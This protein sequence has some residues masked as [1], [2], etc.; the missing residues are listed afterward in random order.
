MPRTGGEAIDPVGELFGACLA[1]K[2]PGPGVCRICCG[3][4]AGARH[5]C[6]S[7]QRVE[8]GLGRALQPV[9]PISLTTK[10]TALYSALRQ[11]KG[12]PN[13]VS[14]RQRRRLAALID[15]F[16]ERHAGCVAPEGYDA[17][18]VVPSLEIGFRPHPLEATMRMVGLGGLGLVDALFARGGKIARN[19]ASSDAYECRSELVE[20]RRVL[21]VDDVYTT[22]AHLHSAAAVLEHCGARSVHPLVVG[23]HQRLEWEPGRSLIRWAALTEN[24]WS[25]EACVRCGSGLAIRGQL[26][27]ALGGR[28]PHGRGEDPTIGRSDDDRRR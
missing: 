5:Q 22:G 1:V 15:S 27:D 3:P 24:V 2:P 28:S 18:V 6:S 7:C 12:R 14:L 21:L 25:A 4:S 19:V 10:A 16:L 20:G 23:R 17:T 13:R 9:T 26:R 8:H 11:Y